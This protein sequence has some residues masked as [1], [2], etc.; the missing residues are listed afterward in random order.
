MLQLPRS[1]YFKVVI[2]FIFLI[3]LVPII[4]KYIPRGI[5]W[6]ETFRVAGQAVYNG[7]DPYSVEGFRY[8]PWAVL[9][10]LPFAWMP[11]RI[12][13]AAFL[14]TS[15]LAFAYVPF[16]LGAKPLAFM[17]FILSPPVLHCLLNANIDWLP[18][19]GFVLP[20]PIGIF[21]V[22]IKPQVGICVAI[23]W[24]I[25]LLRV[26]QWK[27]AF[28]LLCPISIA[29]LLS[30]ILFG[31]WPIRFV[32]PVSF[33]WN[34]SLWPASIPVGLVLI[35]AAIRR[36]NIKPAM[37]ASPC[38][39][40]YVLLHSWSGALVALSQDQFEMSSAVIGLWIMVIIRAFS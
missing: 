10:T 35:T 34:A 6:F 36:N 8:P 20:P 11:E 14:L 19:L 21:F 32:E 16:K 33:W 18:V 13:R 12:G 25:Q 24:V 9:V 27:K 31:F 26:K 3:G 22:V 4:A 23:F 7:K 40:P 15:L 1:S 17:A 39:S 29:Y 37:A 28:Y 38:F 30:F 2:I 5:D